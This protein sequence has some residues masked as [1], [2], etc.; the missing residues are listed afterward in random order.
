M[1]VDGN[2]RLIYAA[3]QSAKG[4]PNTTPT[5]VFPLSGD[6]AL[7]PSREIIQ[8]PETDASS[9][10]ADSRPVGASPGGA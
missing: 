2:S 4:T 3:K 5:V 9:Q 10:R 7:N 6:G 1:P 8:L